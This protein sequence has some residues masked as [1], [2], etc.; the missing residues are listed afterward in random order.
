MAT[1]TELKNRIDGVTGIQQLV[2]VTR[3]GTLLLQSGDENKRLGDYV[4][5]IAITA[6]QLKPYLGFTGPYHMVMEQNSGDRILT[7]PGKQVVIGLNLDSHV[8][9]TV[10]VDQLAPLV[11]QIRI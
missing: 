9:P 4:A 10:I 5:Y 7:L 6:E 3:D 11:D 8:S 2:V 1:L